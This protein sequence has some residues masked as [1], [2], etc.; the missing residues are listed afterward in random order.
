MSG[1]TEHTGCSLNGNNMNHMIWPSQSLG[2]NPIEQLWENLDPN[3][4]M[5]SGWMVFIL[6][7]EIYAKEQWSCCGGSWWTNT[8]LRPLT[9]LFFSPI[10]IC[11]GCSRRCKMC[12]CTTSPK[13]PTQDTVGFSQQVMAHMSFLSSVVL[14]IWNTNSADLP[15]C[16]LWSRVQ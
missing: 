2:L 10:C 6:P 15:C 5:S 11:H 4:G 9:C 14:I 13:E 7:V 3:K 16:C 12:I 8:L 1:Q